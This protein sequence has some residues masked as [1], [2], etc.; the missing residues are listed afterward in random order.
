MV[1]NI[2]H[3]VIATFNNPVT[4]ADLM[5]FNGT[6]IQSGDSCRVMPQIVGLYAIHLPI[7]PSVYLSIYLAINTWGGSLRFILFVTSLVSWSPGLSYTGRTSRLHLPSAG[8]SLAMAGMS[9]TAGFPSLWSGFSMPHGPDVSF[10]SAA[11]LVRFTR[12]LDSLS[13]FCSALVKVSL[14]SMMMADFSPV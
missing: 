14:G 12:M 8:I 2:L 1:F 10:A 13:C 3:Y 4:M 9:H 5:R 11:E 6:T 7:C